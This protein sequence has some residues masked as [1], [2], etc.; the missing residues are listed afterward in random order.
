[1]RE[2]NSPLVEAVRSLIAAIDNAESS[3]IHAPRAGAIE[4]SA[5]GIGT[6]DVPRRALDPDE[7]AAIF[8][9]EIVERDA[10]AQVLEQSGRLEDAAQL[11]SASDTLADL[12]HDIVR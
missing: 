10:T 6:S 1:M 4:A 2:H 8:D 7:V 5:S 12:R 11:R 3:G 9:A